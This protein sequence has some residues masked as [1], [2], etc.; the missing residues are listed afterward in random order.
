MDKKEILK[1]DFFSKRA[2]ILSL[3]TID[4]LE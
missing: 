1:I 4:A 2:F 3:K